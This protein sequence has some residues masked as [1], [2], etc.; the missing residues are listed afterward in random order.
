LIPFHYC[1]NGNPQENKKQQILVRMQGGENPYTMLESMQISS[2][3]M[4]I[5]MEA[6]QKIKNRTSI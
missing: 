4:E 2:A 5:S 6:P 3:I 1:Q